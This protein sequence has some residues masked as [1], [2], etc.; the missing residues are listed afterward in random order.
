MLTLVSLHVE[1]NDH[2][3]VPGSFVKAEGPVTAVTEAGP[4]GGAD[5]SITIA[6]EHGDVTFVIPAGFGPTGVVVGDQVEA[7]GTASTTQGGQPTLVRLEA[8]DN[9]D[10]QGNQGTT[11]PTGPQGDW[12]G[13]HHHDG[14][15]GNDSGDGSGGD[16]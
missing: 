14:S 12:G 16:D 8:Q 11:G 7:K 10:N 3:Q 2:G 5:G 13:H 4:A 15:G 6:D 9:Q 1:G